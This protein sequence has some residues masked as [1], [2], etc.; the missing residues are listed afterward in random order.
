[1][2]NVFNLFWRP[3]GAVPVRGTVVDEEMCKHFGVACDPVKWYH[4]WFDTIGFDLAMGGSFAKQREK[5]LAQIANEQDPKEKAW[6]QRTLE[7]VDWLD[8]NFNVDAFVARS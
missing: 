8:A 6:D 5:L 7:I 2:P 1:M 4:Y 3:D